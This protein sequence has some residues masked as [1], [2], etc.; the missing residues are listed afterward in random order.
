MRGGMYHPCELMPWTTVTQSV[1]PGC[2]REGAELLSA[3]VTTLEFMITPIWKPVSSKL[4]MSASQT[5]HLFLVFRTS[6]NHAS[7]ATGSSASCLLWSFARLHRRRSDLVRFT[8]FDAQFTPTFRGTSSPRVVTIVS[9]ISR[10]YVRLG[11]NPLSISSQTR[12]SRSSSSISVSLH[13]AGRV[14]AL[15]RRPARRV[16]R[17]DSGT[18][19]AFAA[20]RIDVNCFKLS[21]LTANSIF[22]SV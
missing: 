5:P 9:A 18:P 14:S 7:T 20:W 11:G 1:F 10:T 16:R 12:F 21:E 3:L 22:P 8:K 6:L 17:V 19:Y 4:K 15:E 2:L 13:V